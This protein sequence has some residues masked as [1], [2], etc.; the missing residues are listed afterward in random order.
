M[1][2]SFWIALAAVAICTACGGGIGSYDEGMEAQLDSME[3]LVAVLEGV[4]DEGSAKAATAKIESIGEHMAEVAMQMSELP[5]PDAQE[6]QALLE[7][8]GKRMQQFQGEAVEQLM[9]LAKYQ[10]LMDAY[11]RAMANTR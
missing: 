9:K 2:R 10:D 7:K 1:K 4:T 11:T 3:E 8:Y 6:M 5:Q